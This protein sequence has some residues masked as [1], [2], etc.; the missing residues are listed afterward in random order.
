MKDFKH[1][2]DFGKKKRSG[3]DRR[4][5][6][7][8]GFSRGGFG[9]GGGDSPRPALH[10]ATC[11]ECGKPCEVPFKP[12]GDRPVYCSNC[13]KSKKDGFSSPRQ[14]NRDFSKPRFESPMR[15]SAPANSGAPTNEQLA[16]LNAKL[17]K[18]LSILDS[19][20]VEDEEYDEEEEIVASPAP[21]KK[22]KKVKAVKDKKT[23]V[24]K[25][26]KSKKKNG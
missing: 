4:D 7:N 18:I 26:N 16:K 11:A 17:D 25:I 24:K 8:H 23:E 10:G 12:S 2:G 9:H 19:I 22:E 5:S 3:F 14:D 21:V 13:F 1:S 6:G 20:S 15:P